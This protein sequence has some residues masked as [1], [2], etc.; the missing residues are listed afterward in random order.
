MNVND[1]IVFKYLTLLANAVCLLSSTISFSTSAAEGITPLQPGATTG[2]PAGLLPPE[3]L[4]LSVDLDYETGYV[5][6][7][8]NKTA[9]TPGGTKIKAQNSS[10]VASLLWVPGW[11]VLGARYG[12]AIAQPYK[13]QRTTVSNGDGKSITTS[14]GMVNTSL[15]PLLLSWDLGEGFHL[16]SGLAVV[17]PNGKFDYAYDASA[18][19]NV[20]SATTIGNHY[21]TFQPNI[22]LTY[23]YEDWAFTMNN[24]IDINTTNHTTKYKSGNTYYL[25]LTAN[26][27][28]GNFSAG[29]IGSYIQ[30]L[31][32]DKVNG[33][34][35]AAVDNFYSRGNKV[36][37]L[38]LGPLLGYNFGSFSVSAR[39]LLPLRTENDCNCS[40]FHLGVTVPIK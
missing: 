15:I 19:R 3:G 11:A 10:D 1:K 23:L 32:N 8:A 28:F 33:Q 5:K 40:F 14:D 6:N 20:K 35:V 37:H 2:N 26:K 34:T 39:V 13:F 17:L 31:T 29:V 38:Y 24:I 22:A 21:W 30:Q 4:Y 9:R 27:R 18:G 25:D 12:M 7:G 16:G 36:Q